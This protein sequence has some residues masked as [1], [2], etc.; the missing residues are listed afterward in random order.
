MVPSAREW[1]NPSGV[2]MV[3]SLG[4]RVK[5]RR[6]LRAR[7]GKKGMGPLDWNSEVMDEVIASVVDV[8]SICN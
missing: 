8:G 7:E 5:K 1:A 4:R 6:K 2:S 3:I